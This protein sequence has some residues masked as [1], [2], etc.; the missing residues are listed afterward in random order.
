MENK[1]TQ[2]PVEVLLVEDDSGH[3]ELMRFAFD[4]HATPT[5]IAVARSLAEA[6]RMLRESIPDIAIVESQLSDGRGIALLARAGE[7]PRFPVVILTSRRGEREAVDALKAGALDYVVKSES[8]FAELPH[9]AESALREWHKIRQQLETEEALRE[10]EERF[11]NLIEGSIQ[12]ILIG[13]D[14]TPLFV[15]QAYAD[16]LGY[17]SPEEILALGSDRE[18][19]AP[20]ERE[21][22]WSYHQARLRGDPAPTHYEFDAVRKDGSIVSLQNAAR[23]VSWAGESAVQS[24]V[25]DISDR[26]RAEAALQYRAQLEEL[27]TSISASF[28]NL[29]SPEIDAGIKQALREIGEFAAVDRS[30]LILFS[31]HFERLRE[32]YE[33]SRPDIEPIKSQLKDA[34]ADRLPW[35]TQRHRCGEIVYL[36]SVERLSDDKP[37]KALYRALGI[38]SLVSIPL[39]N[40]G[41]VLG[42]LGFDSVRKETFWTEDVVSILTIVGES[43]ANA[44]ARKEF[45]E[46]LRDSEQR[47]RDFAEIAADWFWE[48]G[49]DL[50][51]TYLSERY[52]QVVGV[53]SSAHVG[54]SYEEIFEDQVEDREKWAQH[55]EDLKACR[56][57][58]V[59]TSWVRT[60][61][62]ARVVR[63]IGRPRFDEH[64]EFLGYRGVGR[65]VTEAHRLNAQIAHQASH[66]A[67]TGL[68][69]RREFERRLERAVS[70]ARH[71][72]TQ[73]VLGYI[74]L[75]QFK[76]VNDVAGHAAGDVLLKRVAGLLNDRIRGRDTLARLGGDEFSLLLE[77]C[78]LEKALQIT[79]SMLSDVR[80]FRFPWEGRSFEV[81]ISVGLISINVHSGSA[82]RILAQADLACYT[83]KRLGKN[84]VHVYRM[85]DSE[86]AQRQS[87]IRRISDLRD[88]LANDQFRLYS[89]PI[90]ALDSAVA[91][92]VH[93]E[94]LLRLLDS[95]GKIVM[96]D[97]FIPAAERYGLMASI[98]RWVIRTAFRKLKEALSEGPEPVIAINLSG[99]SLNDE[100]LLDFVISEFSTS[101]IPPR[102][103]CFEI[104][105]TAAINNFE[106][107]TELIATLRTSGC[108]FA[109]DDFGSGVSSFTYLKHLPVD[110]LKIDGSFVKDMADEPVDRAMVAAI[111]QVGRIM[112]IGTIAECADTVAVIDQLRG[113]GVDYVQGDAVGAALP[114]EEMLAGLRIER[115]THH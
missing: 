43:L 65:D 85:E 73:Y 56:A 12:G 69:N 104:T 51:F 54:R 67:L 9:R 71:N 44:I 21:R 105:E 32:V 5:R 103:V 106:R 96:P 78:P 10:S 20:Y 53:P 14:W 74:D 75:D 84:R 91:R 97:A 89:Q 3:A 6:R 48:M 82:S 112:G 66:D 22:L 39:V 90:V 93:Y 94:V 46:S 115:E 13:K 33:W 88:A 60:D 50:R 17:D 11:R 111:H 35:V 95:S 38:K 63:Q 114:L 76:I 62:T 57:F 25:V 23:I 8:A 37:E 110:F 80:S 68:V 99:N 30:Y 4:A 42:F 31:D 92:P 45:E 47:F 101:G 108:R 16:I 40:D 87:E 72:A 29:S 109:L 61:S 79:D 49:P 107:V 18:L 19:F 2:S 70:N 64:G 27:V 26:K 113:M 100:S 41:Q 58:D 7:T 102:R 36:P 28:I 59:Q 52:Q 15:N 1:P 24:V 81:G 34:P 83:A 77:N 55:L 98:D 86:L